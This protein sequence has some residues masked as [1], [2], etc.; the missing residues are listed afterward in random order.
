M[1]FKTPV[2]AVLVASGFNATL[3]LDSIWETREAALA[4][5]AT[6]DWPYTAVDEM[7]VR[8]GDDK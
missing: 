2:Y 5:A 6:L 3:S 8:L 4:Y 1:R 7:E